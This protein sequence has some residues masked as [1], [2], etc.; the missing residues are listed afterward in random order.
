MCAQESEEN[1]K[2][3]CGCGGE[4]EEKNQKATKPRMNGGNG[5]QMNLALQALCSTGMRVSEIKY[6]TVNA[7]NAGEAVV[8][9]KGTTRSV[10]LPT[11]LCSR[12]SAHAK[13]NG[14]TSGCIFISTGG[15]PVT[16]QSIWAGMKRFGEAAG[17]EP[18]KLFP[19][20][21][22][23]LFA[24]RFY[25]MHRD[26]SLLANMLG[27]KNINTTKKYLLKNGSEHRKAIDALGL[28]QA[29]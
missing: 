3:D 13:R 15:K 28:V 1:A 5:E 18:S 14:I 9:N 21:L 16:R 20:N 6:I 25:D 11:E 24:L 4:K 23:H 26:I 2:A 8:T 12:L 7:I 29:C 27:H 19:H 10:V 22:R 17:I